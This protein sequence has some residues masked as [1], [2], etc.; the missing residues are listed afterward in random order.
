MTSCLFEKVGENNHSGG[1]Y[2]G[3]WGV[4]GSRGDGYLSLFGTAD[5]ASAANANHGLLAR[6]S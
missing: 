4:S 2:A 1:R 6:I 3:A 5:E